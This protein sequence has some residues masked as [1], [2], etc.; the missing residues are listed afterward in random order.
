[1]NEDFIGRISLLSR[2]VHTG[3]QIKRVLQRYGL[4]FKGRLD[5]LELAKKKVAGRPTQWAE[6]EALETAARRVNDE[7]ITFSD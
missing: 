7:T 1:M 2:R 5:E 6:L 3:L 4:Q